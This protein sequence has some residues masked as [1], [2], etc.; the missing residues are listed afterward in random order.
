MSP[1]PVKRAKQ[2]INIQSLSIEDQQALE[3]TAALLKKSVSQLLGDPSEDSSHAHASY[4]TPTL[5]T[6][7]TQDSSAAG[8]LS[9]SSQVWFT[10][11][12]FTQLGEA[13][14]TA[15]SASV[16]QRGRMNTTEFDPFGTELW[17]DIDIT[18]TGSVRSPVSRQDLLPSATPS[19]QHMP[20]GEHQIFGAQQS[21]WTQ[22]NAMSRPV[23]GG[24]I[25]SSV[26][27]NEL[28]AIDSDESSEVSEPNTNLLDT[29]PWENVQI[30]S[31]NTVP[32]TVDGD[33]LLL[34]NSDVRAED[35][36]TPQADA[37]NG[38]TQF[39][40]TSGSSK[41][42]ESPNQHS[43]R[44]F[45]DQNL[46]NET[47]NTRK[48]KACVRCRMQKIRVRKNVVLRSYYYTNCNSA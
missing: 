14:P 43:R 23:P 46:R 1:A 19:L 28:Y 45:L 42:R 48:L 24:Q 32:T 13:Q 44:P 47:S 40:R 22:S 10:G 17:Q 39:I 21:G 25:D 20:T 11:P 34:E 5:S 3:R 7:I 38:C 16:G 6:P 12:Q 30:A 26:E 2:N 36:Q 8:T 31:V 37:S 18:S 35:Q 41:D 33:F 9:E 15:Y 4:G 27:A 29:Q